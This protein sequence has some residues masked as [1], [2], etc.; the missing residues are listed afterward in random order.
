MSVGDILT[1]VPDDRPVYIT[2]G[3]PLEQLDGLSELVVALAR[4]PSVT[5]ATNGT[6]P[7]PHWWYNVLWDVDC[8]CPSSGINAFDKSWRTLGRH[9]TIKFV[10][11]DLIDLDFTKEEVK[12]LKGPLCP[13][14]VVS[15]VW[16]DE[17]WRQV[18]WSFCVSQNLRFSLQSHKVVFGDK[19]GV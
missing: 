7:R 12:D 15:P 14:I 19:K 2:G 6:L 10:V 9:N 18:V 17:E 16:G 13:T 11:Q 1:E 8:K 5:I 3:E 4:Y